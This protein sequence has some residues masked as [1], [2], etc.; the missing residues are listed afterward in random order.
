MNIRKKNK[1]SQ[2]TPAMLIFIVLGIMGI[3]ILIFIAFF[4]GFG[5]AGE[6]TDSLCRINAAGNDK[7]IYHT[8]TLV[9]N[10]ACHMKEVSMDAEGKD[11][12][13]KS[14]MGNVEE[15]KCSD[16]YGE[17]EKYYPEALMDDTA[18]TTTRIPVSENKSIIYVEF[19]KDV[20]LDS[21]TLDFEPPGETLNYKLYTKSKKI[22]FW[23][24][25]VECNTGNIV[26]QL[27]IS[28][29]SLNCE[30]EET[31]GAEVALYLNVTDPTT[32]P[33]IAQDIEFKN[34]SGDVIPIKDITFSF[35]RVNQ[36]QEQCM[37]AAIAAG[38]NKECTN[39][40]EKKWVEKQILELA[41]RCWAMGGKG[42]YYG[43]FDCFYGCVN[44]DDT[45]GRITKISLNDSLKENL[46][47]DSAQKDYVSYSNQITFDNILLSDSGYLANG[48][49][50][51]IRYHHSD[52]VELKIPWTDV[53]VTIVP[54]DTPVVILGFARNIGE[55]GDAIA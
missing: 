1:K 55:A 11:T 13:F 44:Y 4:I 31:R 18:S 48:R 29:S 16:F 33:L 51:A 41:M 10:F 8:W 52:R 30:V 40:W 53:G 9:P 50:Y 27:Q 24:D 17:T 15:C 5:V 45:A 37:Q 19:D 25:Y 46:Y 43:D 14:R 34:T 22:Y 26:N 20:T 36:L 32:L 3:V 42:G 38:I 35:K 47:Y 6:G 21:I 54:K 12:F 49:C 7:T 2:I 28:A 39:I 23:T